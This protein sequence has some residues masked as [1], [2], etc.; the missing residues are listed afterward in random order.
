MGGYFLLGVVLLA[1]MLLAARAFTRAS[2]GRLAQGV[3][4]FI[5]AF[6]VLAGT[7]L[8]FAG[9]LGLALVTLGAAVMAVRAMK[10]APGGFGGF[11][12][13]SSGGAAPRTSA[14]ATDTLNMTLDHATGDLEGEVL[15]GPYAGRSLDSLGVSDLMTLL[16][17]CRREDPRSVALLETYLDRRDG[18]W[19]SRAGA[20]AGGPGGGG[21]GATGGSAM[22]EATALSILGLPRGAGADEIK[23][24]HRRLMTRLHPDHGGSSYL[25]AQLNQAKDFLLGRHG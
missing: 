24:A 11:T 5:A 2:P 17:W 21:A 25:A 4:A 15:Q 16:A 22:D 6:S 8:L 20:D 18:D 9:R 10:R 3:R 23:A 13:G 12:G 7:G 1:A 19:R 14:V